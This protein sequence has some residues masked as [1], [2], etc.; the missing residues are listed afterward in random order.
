MERACWHFSKTAL[1]NQYYK[2]SVNLEAF[3]QDGDAA[4][5]ITPV[6]NGAGESEIVASTASLVDFD[7]QRRSTSLA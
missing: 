5:T 3:M 4:L 2:A 6:I 1:T 7:I